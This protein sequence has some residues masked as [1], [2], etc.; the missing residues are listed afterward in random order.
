MAA[1]LS[2][3]HTGRCKNRFAPHGVRKI[4]SCAERPGMRYRIPDLSFAGSRLLPYS[5]HQ[6][7]GSK[8]SAP[9]LHS[10]QMKS[11]GNS[12]PS[13]TYPQ[14]LHTNPFFCSDGAAGFGLIWRK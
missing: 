4:Q 13:Y 1:H 8:S 12:S 5:C 2:L 3:Q 7:N 11:G 14:I 10:G 6:R 9:C